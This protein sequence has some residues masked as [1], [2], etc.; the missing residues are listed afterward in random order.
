MAELYEDWVVRPMTAK[1][2]REL[3]SEEKIERRRLKKIID[4]KRRKEKN[5][6]YR[7]NY[8]IKNREKENERNRQYYQEHK[9]ERDEFNRQY[10]KSP[11]GKKSNTIS[12]WKQNGLQESPEDLDS[13]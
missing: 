4:N 9:E 12:H 7:R 1:E 5:P 10:A 13:I 11:A 3:S 8:H 2:K 6:D